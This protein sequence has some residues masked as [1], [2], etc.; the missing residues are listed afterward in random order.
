M[1]VSENHRILLF[2]QLCWPDNLSAGLAPTKSAR[3]QI[4]SRRLFWSDQHGVLIAACIVGIA[5]D[6]TGIVDTDG[7]RKDEAGSRGNQRIEIDQPTRSGDEGNML[8]R[9]RR[10]ILGLGKDRR[11]DDLASDINGFRGARRSARNSA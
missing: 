6:L 4:Q 5:E 3:S 1:L 8:S 7:V 2:A 9:L 10:V 11:T